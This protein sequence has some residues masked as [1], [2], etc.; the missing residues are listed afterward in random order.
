L[1]NLLIR[2]AKKHAQEEWM[3]LYVERW[4]KGR[5]Q[6]EDGQLIPREKDSPQGSVMTL[7]RGV[8]D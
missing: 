5:V 3:V 7:E 8:A 2:A 6:E 4:L 1:Q